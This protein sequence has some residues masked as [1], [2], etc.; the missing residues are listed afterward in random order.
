MLWVASVVPSSSGPHFDHLASSTCV[1]HL[2]PCRENLI[3]FVVILYSFGESDSLAVHRY[4]IMHMLGY[5]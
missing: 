3:K 4:H 1:Q 2:Q 5:F